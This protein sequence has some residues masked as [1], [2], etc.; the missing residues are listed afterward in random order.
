MKHS[1]ILITALVTICSAGF[2]APDKELVL[3]A[4]KD[5][6]ARSSTRNR[7]NGGSP[8]LLVVHA[9][10]ARSIVGFDLAGIT[11]EIVSAEFQFRQN[12]TMPARDPIDL[13]VAP[14]VHTKNN[15]AWNE[16]GGNFGTKGRIAVEGDSTFAWRSFNDLPWESAP[17]KGVILMSEASLW[18]PPT[19]TLKKLPWKEGEWVKV[20]IK[21]IAMLEKIRESDSPIFTLGMWGTAG[22]GFYFISSKESAHASKLTLQLKVEDEKQK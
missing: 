2:A 17:G 3:E 10:M 16:G 15:A 21:D 12:N 1:T 13:V 8:Q 6:F 9:P 22:N 11:N 7:N 14:M 18:A 5:T 20:P 4:A 19:A